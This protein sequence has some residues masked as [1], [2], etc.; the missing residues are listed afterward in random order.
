VRVLITGS[1]YR[2]AVDVMTVLDNYGDAI[3]EVIVGDSS[4]ADE[5]ARAW[6]KSHHIPCQVFTSDWTSEDLKHLEWLPIPNRNKLMIATKPD[7]CL[8]F[9]MKNSKGTWDCVRKAREANVHVTI[10]DCKDDVR[11][12]T[13]TYIEAIPSDG[14]LLSSSLHKIHDR[15]QEA[16]IELAGR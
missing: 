3:T 1:K 2:P 7:L 6:A 5:G 16:I 13:D 9:P 8:A 11:P 10:V 15:Y 4:G 12:T 14:N